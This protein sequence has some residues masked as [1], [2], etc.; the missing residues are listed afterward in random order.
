MPPCLGNANRLGPA[1]STDTRTSSAACRRNFNAS[2]HAGVVMLSTNI[3]ISDDPR[4]IRAQ[5]AVDIIDAELLLSWRDAAMGNVG[6]SRNRLQKAQDTARSF[7]CDYI[8]APS[9]KPQLSELLGRMMLLTQLEQNELPRAAPA[10]RRQ[11]PALAITVCAFQA[12]PSHRPNHREPLPCP[13]RTRPTPGTPHLFQPAGRHLQQLGQFSSAE[14]DRWRPVA[15]THSC[16][17]GDRIAGMA[18]SGR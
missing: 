10:L 14:I 16:K 17:M 18:R 9:L 1:T 7:G 3:R 6:Q 5:H 12:R 8:E 2:K 11:H 15:V 4:G 13:R